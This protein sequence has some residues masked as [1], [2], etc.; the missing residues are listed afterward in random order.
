MKAPSFEEESDPIFS[1]DNFED[2]VLS[3]TRTAGSPTEL[4][5]EDFETEGREKNIQWSDL[6]FDCTAVDE[7]AAL[8]V[9]VAS[10][11]FDDNLDL[12]DLIRT[13]AKQSGLKRKFSRRHVS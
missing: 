7:L 1:L 6:Y 10:R 4:K 11:C 9:T 13:V 2:L 5:D 12:P 8:H 3:K